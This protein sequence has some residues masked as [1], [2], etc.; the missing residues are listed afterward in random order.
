M[1]NITKA[2]RKSIGDDCPGASKEINEYG[3]DRELIMNYAKHI[4]KSTYSWKD[5][6]NPKHNKYHHVNNDQLNV[7]IVG[8][9]ESIFKFF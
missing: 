4:F 5:I 6:Y 1:K 7:A 8:L 9:T 2:V 3:R